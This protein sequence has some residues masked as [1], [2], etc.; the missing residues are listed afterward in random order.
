MTLA[1]AN[2]FDLNVV[3][4]IQEFKPLDDIT[5]RVRWHYNTD[6]PEDYFQFVFVVPVGTTVGEIKDKLLDAEFAKGWWCYD[7]LELYEQFDPDTDINDDDAFS[8]NNTV[9][10]LILNIRSDEED[11]EDEEEDEDGDY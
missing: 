7:E 9:L 10:T 11:E 4:R 2:I 1:F 8:S 3:R 5:I 6:D